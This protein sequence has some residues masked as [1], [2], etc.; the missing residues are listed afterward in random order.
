MANKSAPPPVRPRQARARAARAA[1][2]EHALRLFLKNGYAATTVEQI[3]EVSDISRRTFFRYFQSK[4]DVVVMRT[5]EI[6]HRLG[7]SLL[8]RPV[9]ERGLESI[10]Q[11]LRP[12][13]AEYSRDPVRTRAI[14]RLTFDTPELRARLKDTMDAW[15]GTLGAAIEDRFPDRGPIYARTLATVAF[16]A[17][18][19]ATTQWLDAGGDLGQLVDAS[20]DAFAHIND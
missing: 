12:I 7:E 10:R 14:L 9:G 20:L 19:I 3:A 17:L 2:R 13:V 15:T 8:D 4:E 1:V 18:N 6:G 5:E 11:A 16:C